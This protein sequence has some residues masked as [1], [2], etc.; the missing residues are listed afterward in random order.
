MMVQINRSDQLIRSNWIRKA[1]P[2]RPIVGRELPTVGHQLP[3]EGCPP[4]AGQGLWRKTYRFS[5]HKGIPTTWEICLI[6][7]FESCWSY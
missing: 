1:N 2:E 4:W 5:L 7:F 6:I 3:T